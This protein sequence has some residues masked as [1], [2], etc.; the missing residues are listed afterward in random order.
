MAST[1]FDSDAKKYVTTN[2]YYV[3][4]DSS[5]ITCFFRMCAQATWQ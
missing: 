5:I 1:E 3:E 2:R 4:T